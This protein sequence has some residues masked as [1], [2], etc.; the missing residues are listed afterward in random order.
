M[1]DSF[2]LEKL[3]LKSR[4]MQ[5]LKSWKSTSFNLNWIYH[6]TP[7]N[8]KYSRL[9]THSPC[10]SHWI[11]CNGELEVSYR[12]QIKILSR[13]ESYLV[14]PGPREVKVLPN[15]VIL[16]MGF[17]LNNSHG[18]SLIHSTDPQTI[19]PTHTHREPDEL[20]AKTKELHDHIHGK[21]FPTAFTHPGFDELQIEA[22]DYCT[23][24]SLL[25]QWLGIL[26]KRLAPSGMH[27]DLSEPT[28]PLIESTSKTLLQNPLAGP[29]SPTV[30]GE[31]TRSNRLG[32]R[33]IEQRFAAATGQTIKM[34]REKQLWNQAQN[35]VQN[36]RISL[37]EI[38]YQL[39]F[40]NPAQFSTWFK[41]NAGES[42]ARFRTKQNF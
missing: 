30:K 33:R 17:F 9:K 38:A 31:I 14:P 42:P 35:L 32:W 29:I 27:I 3:L 40:K 15:Q 4:N 16:S 12:N 2:H 34:F 26:C 1:I 10:Y 11:I 8:G 24:Q 25:F 7:G 19:T 18:Q 13:N 21:T 22:H 28:D 6:G 23:F 37:K 41:K 39:G 20:R 36:D 5:S